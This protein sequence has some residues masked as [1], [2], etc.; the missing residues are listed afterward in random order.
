MTGS[1]LHLRLLQI[2]EGRT[3]RALS[4]LTGVHAEN[5]RRYMT[6][7]T[8]SIEFIGGLCSALNVNADWL[9]TGRGPMRSTEMP[10]HA[11]HRADAAEILQAVADSIERLQERVDRIET[12]VQ[13]MEARLR[14]A[15]EPSRDAPAPPPRSRSARAERIADALPAPGRRPPDAR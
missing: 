7:Q 2:T 6:G 1:P 10:K 11:I 4:E 8:P 5:V 12:Y 14:A 13:T 3:F 15:Q 9:L